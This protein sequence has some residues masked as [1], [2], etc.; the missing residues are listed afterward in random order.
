MPGC[1]TT[2]GSST[3]SGS[4]L[5]VVVS[6]AGCAQSPNAHSHP[7]RAQ[8]ALRVTLPDSVAHSVPAALQVCDERAR[9]MT[10]EQRSSVAEYFS[11]YKGSDHG[12]KARAATAQRRLSLRA[13]GLTE[14]PAA[15]LVA[16]DSPPRADVCSEQRSRDL[17]PGRTGGPLLKQLLAVV[18]LPRAGG[19]D[20][21]SAPGAR[22]RE[23]D[24][25]KDFPRGAKQSEAKEREPRT[26]S[27]NCQ[28]LPPGLR[29]A[30]S[31]PAAAS[32]GGPRADAVAL[33]SMRPPP[34][35]LRSAFS[36]TRAGSRRRSFGARFS[37]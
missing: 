11:V 22:P 18:P 9:L 7:S 14:P 3:A 20:P 2:S 32:G 5:G 13:A 29:S 31:C 37:R 10:N 34:P 28:H 8:R 33:P 24:P 21:E 30:R 6:I 4:T 36:P 12:K 25:D 35:L 27:L 16:L 1:A 23:G 15:A 26:N 17:P 19:P